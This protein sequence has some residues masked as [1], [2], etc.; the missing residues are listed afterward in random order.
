MKTCVVLGG[1]SDIYKGLREHLQQDYIIAPWKRE[2]SLPTCPW[3][4]VL[5]ML[6]TVA[7]VGLWHEVDEGDWNEGFV[8]NLLMPF[9]LLR[10]LWQH[11]N[12]GASIC[13][14][15]GSNPNMIM[16]G[17]SAYNVSKMALLK[18]V[19][20]LDHETPDAKFFAL[21]PGTILTKIHKPSLEA[22][23]NNPKLYKAI[24]EGKEADYKRLYDRLKWCVEQPKY[25]VGGRNICVSDDTYELTSGV[26]DDMFKLRRREFIGTC[27]VTY[28]GS[29][30]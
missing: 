19:E 7:P 29:E 3:D 30:D 15:A 24:Q 1:N 9:H 11:H 26:S 13:M 17:Y 10:E 6:G 18:L 8:S 21:G 20:Q 27:D 22:D 2:E 4:L 12:P 23:W 16:D 5:C 14:M 28:C 25:V